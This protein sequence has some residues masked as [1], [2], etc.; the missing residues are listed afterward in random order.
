MK[1]F[2]RHVALAAGM[3][4]TAPAFAALETLVDYDQFVSVDGDIDRNLW[5]PSYG[6]VE[7]IRLINT[8]GQLELGQRVLAKGSTNVGSVANTYGLNFYAPS[9]VKEISAIIKVIGAWIS[10]CAANT[11]TGFTS[12][13]IAGSFFNDGGVTAG[14]QLNDIIAQVRLERLASSTAAEGT[15]DVV[16]RVDKCT[17]ADCSTTTQLYRGVLQ[18]GLPVNTAVRVYLR[19]DQAAKKFYFKK[20]SDAYLTYTYTVADTVAP[21]VAF[22]GLQNRT[23]IENCVATES[24]ARNGGSRAVFD[25]VM[26]NASADRPATPVTP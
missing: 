15:T 14:S 10:P 17:N 4:A 20:G 26:V 22:K 5:G 9:A 21:S 11:D 2:A 8:S 16:A 18:A 12:A 6:P 24:W 19:W 23:K 7:Q 13:R 25:G 3:I 1:K